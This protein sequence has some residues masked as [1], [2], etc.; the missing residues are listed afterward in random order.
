MKNL[1]GTVIWL[2]GLPATGKT[3]LG[4]LLHQ[5][6]RTRSLPT[7]WLDSDDLRSVMTP[8]PTYSEAERDVFYG[9]LGHVATL[10]ADSG[11]VVIVSATGC[12]RRYRDRV[13]AEVLR[14]EEILL[15]CDPETLR[16]RD[17]KGL[18]RRAAGGSIT[19]LPG[20]GAP[21]EDPMAPE[22]VLDTGMGSPRELTELILRHLESKGSEEVAVRREMRSQEARS[23]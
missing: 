14:F 12:K 4:E 11:I 22:M 1:E 16:R 19:S 20:I 13:R 21:Y 5:E 9:T 8:T 15:I 10:A 7:L 6:L 2:T 18:Y 17:P 3:T 23:A